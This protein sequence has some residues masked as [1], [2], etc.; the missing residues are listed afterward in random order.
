LQ[1][2]SGIENLI[3][4]FSH[5]KITLFVPESISKLW[6]TTDQVGFENRMDTGNGSQLFLLVEKDYACI[7]NTLEDRSYNYPNPKAVC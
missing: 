1:R 7:D 6:T 4:E 3:A 5:N 2:K